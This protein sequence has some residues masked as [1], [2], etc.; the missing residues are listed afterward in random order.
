MKNCPF[1]G[2]RIED[3]AVK[4]SSCGKSVSVPKPKWYF[5]TTSV[6]IALLVAGPFALPLVWAHPRYSKPVK[7]VITLIV[8]VITIWL[9]FVTKD[10]MALLTGQLQA[11]G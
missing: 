10:L 6:V 4:C 2:S 8:V 3:D 11:L 5:S 1:C 9:V 7:G